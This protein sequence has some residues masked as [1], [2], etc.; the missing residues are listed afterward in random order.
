MSFFGLDIAV[1]ALRA[2]QQAL[3]VT[4]H[5][6]ANAGTDGYHRQEAVFVPS[7]T[8]R[9]SFVVGS[10][11][12]GTGVLVQT[13]RRV[14]NTYIENQVRVQNQE[15]GM[16]DFRN[17]SLQ[18]V[19]A[20]L[21]E[22]SDLGLS[23]TLD[24]FWN[25]WEELSATPDSQTA[26][27]SVVQAGISLSDRIRSLYNSFQDL[28]AR[29]DRALVDNASEI[30]RLA[31]EIADINKEI[32]AGSDSFSQPNDLLDKRDQL[33]DQLSRLVPIQVNGSGGLNFMISVNGKNLIQGSHVVEVKTGSAPSGW[34]SLVWSDDGTAFQANGGEVSAQLAI[35]M[36][37]SEG[38][39][40][41]S[42]PS[43]KR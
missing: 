30:N 8:I 7:T 15:L 28:Q 16:W 38:I 2:Q 29:A 41:L 23:S 3:S 14:Q 18:Q 17:E 20:V 1:S 27:I 43:P 22:P 25:S 21:G 5:N 40:T 39:L 33:I 42:T 36:M 19:E 13:V 10:P 35:P 26:R 11:Q 9:T 32:T 37:F 6:I 34:T 4:G 24:K 12:L 31:H